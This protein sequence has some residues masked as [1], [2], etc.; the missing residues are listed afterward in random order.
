MLLRKAGADGQPGDSAY[1]LYPAAL[2]RSRKRR[3]F[4][5]LEP[6]V[7]ESERPA[8]EWL[9]SLERSAAAVA[10]WPGDCWRAALGADS[11]HCFPHRWTAG[12]WTSKGPTA[13][14]QL[15][16]RGSRSAPSQ[17]PEAHACTALGTRHGQHLVSTFPAPLC[18][19]P[20]ASCVV[21]Q[22]LGA[23]LSDQEHRG[24]SPT[25][26]T[27][28]HSAT[29]SVAGSVAQR[30]TASTERHS[31]TRSVAARRATGALPWR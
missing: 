5:W 8:L 23:S 25:A 21:R 15:V 10:Q 12:R 18:T 11:G 7:L 14:T 20:R 27:E 4:V 26:S 3:T 1:G 9:E 28:R 16:R 22:L 6:P 30:R 2:L 17:A 29:G 13:L 19:A 31:A 24:V